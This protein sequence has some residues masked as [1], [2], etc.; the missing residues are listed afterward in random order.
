MYFHSRNKQSFFIVRSP[1]CFLFPFLHT[2]P[3][4][5]CDQAYVSS[6][7]IEPSLQSLS[8]FK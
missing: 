6:K 2:L 5:T 8:V 3:G 1:K 7:S 4:Q